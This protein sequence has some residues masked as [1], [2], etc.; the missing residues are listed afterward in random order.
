MDPTL[1][2][3][4][5]APNRAQPK[6][7][8][9]SGFDPVRCA[10]RH[11]HHPG[12]CCS[13]EPPTSHTGAMPRGRPVPAD[14]ILG[15]G[16]SARAVIAPLIAIAPTKTNSRARKL[17]LLRQTGFDAT[18]NGSSASFRPVAGGFL[19]QR[20]RAQRTGSRPAQGVLCATDPTPRHR[21]VFADMNYPAD[22]AANQKRRPMNPTLPSDTTPALLSRPN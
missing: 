13:P 11:A 16:G 10:S 19:C 4:G 17:A 12:K 18:H 9:T 20:S 6:R 21:F 1:E 2:D 14:A 5:S 7:H 15:P 22:G 8:S 3:S